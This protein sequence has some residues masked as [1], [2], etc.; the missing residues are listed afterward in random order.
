MSEELDLHP[1]SYYRGNKEDSVPSAFSLQMP[2][3]GMDLKGGFTNSQPYCSMPV[4]GRINW[5]ARKLLNAFVGNPMI[6]RFVSRADLSLQGRT[7][8]TKLSGLAAQTFIR[9]KN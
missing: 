2:L 1:T 9:I 3:N 5:V 4:L 7:R 8:T 6:Y